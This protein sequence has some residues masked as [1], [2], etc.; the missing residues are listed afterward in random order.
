MHLHYMSHRQGLSSFV[1][2]L[3]SGLGKMFDTPVEVEQIN[4]KDQG[5]EHDVFLVKWSLEVGAPA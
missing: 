4:H 1:C 2:G 3:L 5:S